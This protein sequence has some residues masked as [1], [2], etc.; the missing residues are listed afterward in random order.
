[1]N[2]NILFNNEWIRFENVNEDEEEIL[3]CINEQFNEE[4]MRKKSK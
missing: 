4:E 3:L 1:M 2:Y